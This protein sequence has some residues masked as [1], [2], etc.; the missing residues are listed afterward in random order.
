MGTAP[1]GCE[2]YRSLPY[3]M[4]RMARLDTGQNQ[5]RLLHAPFRFGSIATQ[6]SGPQ[7]RPMSAM[8]PIANKLG[9]RHDLT[10]DA[11]RATLCRPV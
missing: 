1:T 6:G 9:L 2:N 8:P 11:V 7:R 10:D 4:P 5:L 3:G